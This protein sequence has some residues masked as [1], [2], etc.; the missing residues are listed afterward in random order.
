MA[1]IEAPRGGGSSAL[2][3]FAEC[4]GSNLVG[5]WVYIRDIVLGGKYRVDTAIP[6][7]PTKVPAAGI[8]I[9]KIDE[10]N[11]KVQWFGKLKGIVTGLN[12]GKILYLGA[13]GKTSQVPD[14]TTPQP[15]GVAIGEDEILI[16]PD[17][18]GIVPPVYASHLGTTDGSSDARLLFP[19][20]TQGL[21]SD[22][23]VQGVPFWSFSKDGNWSNPAVNHPGLRTSMVS[24]Q[25]PGDVTA[26]D[27]GTTLRIKFSQYSSAGGGETNLEETIVCDGSDQVSS[28][29]GWVQTTG[30]HSNGGR[31]EG[32][33]H[34]NV[35][36]SVILTGGGYLRVRVSHEGPTGGPYLVEWQI[37]YDGPYGAPPTPSDLAVSEL[38]ATLKY[39]SGIRFY[40]LGTHFNIGGSVTD[41]FK[42]MYHANPVLLDLSGVGISGLTQ[43]PYTDLGI[44]PPHPPIPKWNDALSWL[45][46]LTVNIPDLR[47]YDCIAG[48]R[49]RDPWNTSSYNYSPSGPIMVDTVTP[50]SNDTDEPFDDERYRLVPQAT[51][52]TA[53]PSPP[54]GGAE[55]D[56]QAVLNNSTNQ[57]AQ[58]LGGELIYPLTNFLSPVGRSPIQ[59]AGADYSLLTGTRDYQRAFRHDNTPDTRSNIVMYIPGFDV[60]APSDI[61]PEGTGDINM[62]I[63]IPGVSPVWFDCGRQYFSALF[64]TPEPGCLVKSLSGVAAGYPTNEYWYFTFGPY[65]TIPDDRTIIVRVAYRSTPLKKISRLRAYNWT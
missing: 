30:V 7:N 65:S 14:P 46:D 23:T 34:A 59:Q 49:A 20:G 41:A 24:I 17:W 42:A 22:P 40:N 4:L 53:P 28:P 48:Q 45:R 52:L 51:W 37:F 55:F 16:E 39:L 58:V 6:S 5:D 1:R 3:D 62:L 35:P 32:I 21:I 61:D 47:S 27:V 11:C 33:V 19:T 60:T 31:Y 2:I 8:I 56:S 43:L 63:Y 10:T 36:L 29:N 26:L 12:P 9:E 38:S 25:T 64:P 13:A 44:T 50:T 18:T 54:T 57:G 15:L